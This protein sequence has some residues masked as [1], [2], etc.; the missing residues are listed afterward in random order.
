M[1]GNT[2]PNTNEQLQRELAESK[3]LEQELLDL[4]SR[5]EAILAVV[6]ELIME[7]DN[8]N[9]YTWAN[10][11]GFAFFGDDVIGKEAAFY[12]MGEQVSDTAVQPQFDGHQDLICVQSW[13]RRKDG[14]KRLL[15]WQYRVLKDKSGNVTGALSFARDIT[16]QKREDERLQQIEERWLAITESTQYAILMMDP[17]GRVSYWNRAAERMFGHTRVEAI[18]KT[19]MT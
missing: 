8:H 18:G 19:C 5:Q 7:V 2:L 10:Q 17:E 15:A 4:S 13:Q 3:K 16:E 14:E 1:K 12:F 11:A 9:I 6:P